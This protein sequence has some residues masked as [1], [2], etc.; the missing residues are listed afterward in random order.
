[1]GFIKIIQD[2]FWTS[3]IKTIPVKKKRG[4]KEK[5]RKDKIKKEKVLRIDYSNQKLAGGLVSMSVSL[6]D[7]F[8]FKSLRGNLKMF[9]GSTMSKSHSLFKEPMPQI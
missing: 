9:E 6:F 4:K 7:S 2:W 3:F 5:K 1:M 8:R